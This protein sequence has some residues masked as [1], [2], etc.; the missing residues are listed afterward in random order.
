[1]KFIR[2]SPIKIGDGSF[3]GHSLIPI[4]DR[5]IPNINLLWLLSNWE[6]YQGIWGRIQ[7]YQGTSSQRTDECTITIRKF[8][9]DK[10][11]HLGVFS[12]IVQCVF[13]GKHP[14][15]WTSFI[16]PLYMEWDNLLKSMHRTCKSCRTHQCLISMN[17]RLETKFKTKA[18]QMYSMIIIICA[19]IPPN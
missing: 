1:M 5:Y 19:V 11:F 4:D 14:H 10:C 7:D 8:P 6:I 17:L 15:T 12:G 2:D 18:I 13:F 3:V 16:T 9:S